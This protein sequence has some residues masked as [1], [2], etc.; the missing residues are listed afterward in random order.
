MESW[1]LYL[2][3]FMFRRSVQLLGTLVGT[4]KSSE[5]QLNTWYFHL[6]CLKINMYNN[7][8]KIPVWM[9]QNSFTKRLGPLLLYSWKLLKIQSV[10]RRACFILLHVRLSHDS[11]SH[12]PNSHVLYRKLFPT[13][14]LYSQC[15]VVT[16]HGLR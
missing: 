8:R 14:I 6:D 4:K 16:D 1:K 15:F 12:I 13:F 7:L 11:H 3:L 5:H 2:A 10:I 9:Y